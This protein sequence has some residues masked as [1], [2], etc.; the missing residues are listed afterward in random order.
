MK[1]GPHYSVPDNETLLQ[2]KTEAPNALS[3]SQPTDLSTEI[4]A[5]ADSG[6]T[7]QVSI[8]AVS[9][10]TEATFSFNLSGH[11]ACECSVR[12]FL[13]RRV[14]SNAYHLILSKV[15]FTI[16]GFMQM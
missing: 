5:A 12:K 6:V 7:T 9:V 4:V 2:V 14:Q 1:V 15:I 11:T 10:Q 16:V 13:Y 8:S 3:R